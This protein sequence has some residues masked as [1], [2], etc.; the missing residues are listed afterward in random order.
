MKATILFAAACLIFVSCTRRPVQQDAPVNRVPMDHST[1]DHSKMESSPGAADAPYELQF[2]DTMIVH[3]VGAIDAA[4][5]VATRAQHK[6][7]QDMAK[8]IIA[9]QQREVAEMKQWRSQWFG[10]SPQA[11]N[12]DLPGM[13]DGMRD[14][15]LSKLDALKENDFDLEFVRQMIPHHEGAV[16]MAKDALTHDVHPDLKNLSDSIV[17]SQSDEIEKMKTWQAEWQRK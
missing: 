13:R 14:M 4:Q 12:M 3:H 6:A 7:L 5:L 15:D 2:L 1:M 8:A 17:N 10:D 11:V 16:A 9:D